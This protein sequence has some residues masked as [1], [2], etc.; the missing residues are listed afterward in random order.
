MEDPFA[1]Q[2]G[3]LFAPPERRL[4]SGLTPLFP[5]VTLSSYRRSQSEEL[6]AAPLANRSSHSLH[7]KSALL[8]GCVTFFSFSYFYEGGG[9]NQNSRFDLLRAIVERG[10][11]QIDAYQENTEDKVPFNGHFYSD[12]AP[13]LVFL[14]V[15][16][17]LVVR[18]VLRAAGFDLQ[19]P[20]G[21]LWFSYAV[22]AGAV[23]LPTAL[24]GI[25]LYFLGLRLGSS[26]T[27]AAF[28]TMVMCLGSPIWAWASLFWAHALVGACLVFALA[29]ALRLRENNRPR[30][31]IVWALAVGFAAGWATV[32]EYPA[33]PASAMLAFLALS[34]VW[35][36]GRGGAM[37][38]GSRSRGWSGDLCGRAAGIPACR[39]RG[40]SPELFLLRSEF[41]FVHETAGVYGTDVSASGPA[42][43]IVVWMFAR[44]VDCVSRDGGGSVRTVV[45]LEGET[46][47]GSSASGRRD[48]GLLLPIQRFLLLVEG[49][50]NVWSAIRG[51]VH[52]VVLPGTRGDLVESDTDVAACADWAGSVQRCA[53]V[54]GGFDHVAIGDAG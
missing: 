5:R 36:R 4:R 15:P 3:G 35:P 24:A 1:M 33:A 22:S 46:F 8:L 13:G 26:S 39:V 6:M 20:R 50:A 42:A 7:W 19:S 51:G 31:D 53:D 11:L 27:G 45:A 54:D 17:A 30:A 16:V 9:W 41:V 28:A 32:T 49:G 12:K 44:P 29:A 23:A 47:F 38:S 10:T 2:P 18:P 43:E 25:W 14:A 34:Q 48:R 40:L 52:S 21:V 37:E